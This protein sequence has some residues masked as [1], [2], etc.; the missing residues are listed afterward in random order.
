MKIKRNDLVLEIGS[1]ATPHPR[2]DILVDKYF[3]NVERGTGDL[4]IDRPLVI[5]DGEA[6]PFPDKSFD[7]IICSHIL[8]HVEHPDRFLRE[9]SRVGKRGY[10]V[11]PS[12]VAEKL[13]FWGYHK[14]YITKVGDTLYLKRK[15][16]PNLFGGLFHHLQRNDRFFS[17]FYYAHPELFLVELEWEGEVK[18]EI[19]PEDASSPWDLGDKEFLKKITTS[20]KRRLR[21][22]I[23][24]ISPPGWRDRLG[25]IKREFLRRLFQRKKTKKNGN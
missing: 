18:F 21:P 5:A 22:F 10:I 19:L 7:Y 24:L 15:N 8:E 16:L 4:K 13:F 6:L 3:A 2:S 1:G 12:E 17:S 9:I 23:N 14:W 25:E 11:S 20:K